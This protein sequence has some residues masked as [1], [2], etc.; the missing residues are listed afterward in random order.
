MKF[1]TSSKLF[2]YI[3]NDVYT[4]FFYLRLISPVLSVINDRAREAVRCNSIIPL[5]VGVGPSEY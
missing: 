4:I 3:I 1:I 5:G 2:N